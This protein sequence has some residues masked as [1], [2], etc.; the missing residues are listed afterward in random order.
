ME[1]EKL[2]Q[3]NSLKEK[4]IITQEEFDEQKK[5]ILFGQKKNS[6]TNK[7]ILE[8]DKDKN[9]WNNY[10]SCFKKYFQFSGRA[11]RY[12]YWGFVFINTLTSFVLSLIDIF[13]ETDGILNGLFVLVVFIPTLSV[14]VRRLHDVNKSAWTL[15]IP[16]LYLI[17]LTIIGAIINYAFG[18]NEQISKIKTILYILCGFSI[19]LYFIYLTCKKSYANKNKYGDNTIDDRL[20]RIG[21]RLMI[22][23]ILLYVLPVLSVG[24]ISGFSRASSKFMLSKNNDQVA[25]LVSNIRT[26]FHNY[27]TYDGLNNLVAKKYGLV[28]DDMYSNQEDETIISAF[29]TDIAIHGLD[30][31]FSITFFGLSEQECVLVSSSS[32]WGTSSTT[33]FGGT[34]IN[35]ESTANYKNVEDYKRACL[36]CAQGR[37]LVSLVFF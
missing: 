16:F 27:P 29:G 6:N 33:G 14:F 5:K 9:I 25:I 31:T 20:E 23:T 7:D 24:F 30:S 22:I 15:L 37:C 2:E 18:E 32:E 10:L 1:L 17:P 21:K 35:G 36:A 34:I 11:T 28:P 12:E 3:L 13:S 4:G 19:Y 8:A 26:A